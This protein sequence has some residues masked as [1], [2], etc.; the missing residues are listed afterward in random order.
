MWPQTYEMSWKPL[1]PGRTPDLIRWGSPVGVKGEGMGYEGRDRH[2]G[3]SQI[4]VL[5]AEGAPFKAG[6]EHVSDL[7]RSQASDP[8]K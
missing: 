8:S 7:R 6:S 3:E 1:P 5:P 4:K 2:S